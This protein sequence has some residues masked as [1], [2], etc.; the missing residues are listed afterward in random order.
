MGNGKP[1]VSRGEVQSARTAPLYDFLLS[2]H[3]ELFRR[4]GR[5]LYLQGRDAVYIKE[6]FPG[7]ND[8]SS[9]SHGNP[10]DFLTR[11][12]GYGFV[13]AV[14]AL[15][16]HTAARLPHRMADGIV[17]QKVPSSRR[18]VLPEPAEKPFR[19]MYAYLGSRGLPYSIIRELESSGLAYQEKEH[20]NIV[21]VNPERDY[22]ELRGTFTYAGRSFHGCRKMAPDRFWYVTAGEGELSSVYVCEAAIDAVSLLLLHKM[23]GRRGRTVYAS[24]GGVANQK[25]IDRIRKHAA[26]ILAVDNDEAGRKCRERNPWLKAAI[27]IH[28]DW[29]EDLMER[30]S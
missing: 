20:N 25:A 30:R 8:F 15:N 3:P 17:G 10:V 6:G 4:S 19:Q 27:P 16:C 18:I 9:G 14:K 5:C 24:I 29:N 11:Y 7:Y 23:D 1:Y 12:L 28:K 13:D 22:A 21:F 2:R 26:T